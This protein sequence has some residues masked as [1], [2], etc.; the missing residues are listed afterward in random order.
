MMIL[1][2]A[3]DV[4][5]ESK[6]K[7]I[8]E[9]F[10]LLKLIQDKTGQISPMGASSAMQRMVLADDDQRATILL[11]Q[12]SMVMVRTCKDTGAGA[13]QPEREAPVAAEGAP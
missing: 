13:G 5:Y 12:D 10:T 2:H 11:R 4:L 8:G 6:T 9:R 7:N 1:T 3:G